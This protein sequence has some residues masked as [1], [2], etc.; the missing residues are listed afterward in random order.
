MGETGRKEIETGQLIQYGQ[1]VVNI[2]KEKDLWVSANFRESQISG[3]CVGQ[4]VDI[5]V[6]GLWGY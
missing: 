4:P 5:H 6:D 3:L 2:I 1:L